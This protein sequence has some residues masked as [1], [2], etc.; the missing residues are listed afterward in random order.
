MEMYVPQ[1]TRVG[2]NP[3]NVF[4]VGRELSQTREILTGECGCVAHGTVCRVNMCF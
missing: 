2:E 1:Q 3:Y 4:S